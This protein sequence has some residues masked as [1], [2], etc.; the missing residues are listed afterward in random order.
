MESL[1]FDHFYIPIMLML[2]SDQEAA[3]KARQLIRLR[4]PNRE[5]L[6]EYLGVNPKSSRQNKTKALYRMLD[7]IENAEVLRIL[8]ELPRFFGL[9][10][11][12]LIFPESVTQNLAEV[13]PHFLAQN[14]RHLYDQKQTCTSCMETE[15]KPLPKE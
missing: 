10:E 4:N 7:R 3:A 6:A 12:T 14:P 13:V 11:T 15:G 8:R 2:L 1:H 5:R 9:P